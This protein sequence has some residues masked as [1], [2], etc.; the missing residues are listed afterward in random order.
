VEGPGYYRKIGEGG[1]ASTGR[2]VESGGL[3]L[4]QAAYDAGYD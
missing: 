4:G 2:T 1:S 3:D